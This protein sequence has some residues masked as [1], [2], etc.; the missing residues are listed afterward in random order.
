M[1]VTQRRTRLPKFVIVAHLHDGSY[2]VPTNVCSITNTLT[3]TGLNDCGNPVTANVTGTC[4]V[5]DIESPLITCL[6]NLVV[7]ADAGQC[8]RSNVTFTVSATDN[9]T[10]TNLA[11]SPASGS[12]FPIGV[13]T[14]TSTA[15]DASGNQSSCTFTVTV[16]DTQAPAITWVNPAGGVGPTRPRVLAVRP[17][18]FYVFDGWHHSPR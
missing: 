15:N 11:S 17:G 8:S 12:T 2:L 6:S 18:Q 1:P 4:P 7:T 13:T 9:C 5:S 16:L 14:V 10:V 3:A